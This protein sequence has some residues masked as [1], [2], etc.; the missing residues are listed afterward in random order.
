[1]CS[2]CSALAQVIQKQQAEI[3][4]LRKA[5]AA[6]QSACDTIV[7]EGNDV[8]RGNHVPRGKWSYAKGAKEAAETIKRK[9]R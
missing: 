8:L 6:A 5:I 4:M 3:M 2:N 7:T 9:L 1:M